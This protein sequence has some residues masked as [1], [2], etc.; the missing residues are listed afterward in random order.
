MIF[1]FFF[2][3]EKICKCW[4]QSDE[5]NKKRR[6]SPK[7]MTF[8][9]LCIKMCDLIHPSVVYP[10]ASTSILGHFWQ[11]IVCGDIHK[12][13]HQFF[14]IFVST[15]LPFRDN[16][17]WIIFIIFIYKIIIQQNPLPPLFDDVF[18]EGCL[19][20][21]MSILPNDLSQI[22]VKKLTKVWKSTKVKW[23]NL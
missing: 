13:H 2:H 6:K 21:K 9:T 10:F 4:C 1:V 23:D 20:K 16:F 12:T 19:Y 7:F 22:F 14:K 5:T 3:F 11:D 15:R 8:F 17:Y 18:Y